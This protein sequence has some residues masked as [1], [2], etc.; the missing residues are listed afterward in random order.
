MLSILVGLCYFYIK[1]SEPVSDDRTEQFFMVHPGRSMI[2]I[3]RQLEDKKLIRS[4]ELFSLFAR[5]TGQSGKIKVGEYSL[6]SAMGGIEI[7]SILKSGKSVS[8]TVTFK[9]GLNIH[10]VAQI[11]EDRGFATVPEVLAICRDKEFVKQLLGEVRPSLEGYLFPETY[12][13]T[14]LMG[15]KDILRM[16][17]QH[18]FEA[19]KEVEGQENKVSMPRHE[20]VT[21]ASIIEKETGAPEER[22]L[23]SSVFHNRLKKGML[24]QTDPTVIYGVFDQTGV[25]PTNIR[26]S[27]LITP[28]RYNTYTNKG[29]PFGP[30]SNPGKASLIAALNPAESEYLFFVSKNDGTH[31]FTEKYS[32]HSNAVKIYQLDRKAREGK[33][34]RN[35]SNK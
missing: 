10:E 32:D 22:P 18:F 2:S 6:N 29:L 28:N 9:E 16:M 11:L 27:D 23:V 7:L 25:M 1:L 33:S 24:L 5:I 34:W 35:F 20:L 30:I 13:F 21:L 15:A 8:H 26:K 3:S 12:N 14:K 17:V 19:V 4:A 31:V